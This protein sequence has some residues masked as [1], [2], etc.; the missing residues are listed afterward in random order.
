[1]GFD[2]FLHNGDYSLLYAPF[3]ASSPPG[4][5]GHCLSIYDALGPDFNLPSNIL[6]NHQ[7]PTFPSLLFLSL[8]LKKNKPGA[9]LR[10]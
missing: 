10:P 6:R 4:A 8:S 2:L 7:P 3:E 5:A 1:M 9:L